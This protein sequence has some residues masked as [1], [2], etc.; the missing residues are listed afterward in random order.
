[1]DLKEIEELINIFENIHLKYLE[2]SNDFEKII[3]DKKD[4]IYTYQNDYL[5]PNNDFSS[6]KVKNANENT[7]E[8]KGDYNAQIKDKSM[9]EEE[10]I[11]ENSYIIKSPFVGLI[12]ISDCVKSSVGNAHVNKGD[13]LSSIEA[14]KLYNE[15]ISP[16]D[17]IVTDIYVSDASRVEYDQ[18]IMKICLQG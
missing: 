11:E 10:N 9:K 14:M 2:I 1:M 13:I 3:L 8:K 17:G 18:P 6:V 4:N 12:T 7:Y 16:V 5:K 15:I